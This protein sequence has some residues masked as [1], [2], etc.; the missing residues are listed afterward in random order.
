MVLLVHG[1][2]RTPLSLRRLGRR[3]RRAGHQPR[4]FGYVPAVESFDRIL[5]RLR[6]RVRELDAKGTPWAGI[7]HSLG[8]LL[9]RSAIAA[10]APRHL[11]HLIMLGTPNQ[12]PRLAR[13]ASG[14]RPFRWLAGE[15]GKRLASAEYYAHLPRLTIRMHCWPAPTVCMAAGARLATRPTMGSWR[16][17]RCTC[18]TAI[19]CRPFPS[20]IPS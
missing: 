10:E 1:L 4:Y 2:G 20:A 8:G 18:G 7:G 17:P 14:V 15:C 11:V 3:L 9:L 5:S 6:S 19:R 12:P 13:R 16:W